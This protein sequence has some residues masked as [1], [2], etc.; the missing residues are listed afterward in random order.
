M[1]WFEGNVGESGRPIRVARPYEKANLNRRERRWISPLTDSMNAQML[2]LDRD[3]MASKK[4]LIVIASA[5]LSACGHRGCPS[6]VKLTDY[7]N[8]DQCWGGDAHFSSLLALTPSGSN[9]FQP[10]FIS[11]RCVVRHRGHPAWMTP[12]DFPD[13]PSVVGDD[14]LAAKLGFLNKPITSNVFDHLPGPTP[15]SQIYDFEARLEIAVKDGPRH[16]FRI[17][18]IRML[19]PK[20]KARYKMGPTTGLKTG[21]SD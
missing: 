1:R 19:K 16:A 15:T 7:D 6:E 11:T 9:T 14:G 10:T 17:V 20:C 13:K 2:R 8:L 5:L 21:Q 3:K 4:V 12:F 18:E